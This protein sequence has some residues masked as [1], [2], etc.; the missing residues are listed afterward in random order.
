MYY[1]YLTY[2]C[3][4]YSDINLRIIEQKSHEV[5]PG[6]NKLYFKKGVFDLE[7]IPSLTFSKKISTFY[8]ENIGYFVIKDKVI[9]GSK[10]PNC[11]QGIF[12]KNLLNFAVPLALFQ[13]GYLVLHAAALR[14]LDKTILFAGQSG[15]GKSTI[16]SLFLNTNSLISEDKSVIL[17]NDGYSFVLPSQ[18]P[19]IKLSDK[20]N[21][22]KSLR[23]TNQIDKDVSN[24]STYKVDEKVMNNDITRVDCCIFL[25]KGN[26]ELQELNFNDSFKY[27]FDNSI[28]PIPNKKCLET[29]A[30]FLSSMNSFLKSNTK[31]FLYKR[32]DNNKSQGLE[33]MMEVKSMLEGLYKLI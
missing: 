18:I 3:T 30:L 6:G 32:S 2:G 24:R 33:Y 14:Y 22:T 1:K 20:V 28:I 25:E 15:I 4:L 19:L 21:L 23:S 27:I 26:G 12:E 10:H 13:E 17:Y 7:K 11:D 9:I 8:R 16:S 29:N 31:F 5:S